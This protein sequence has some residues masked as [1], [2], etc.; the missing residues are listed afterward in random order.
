MI[1][2]KANLLSVSV[3][4]EAAPQYVIEGGEIVTGL[5]ASVR[6]HP[7]YLRVEIFETRNATAVQLKERHRERLGEQRERK[8]EFDAVPVLLVVLGR[9]YARDHK[10]RRK[11]ARLKGALS[12][13]HGAGKGSGKAVPRPV[14]APR[15]AQGEIIAQLSARAVIDRVADASLLI[16]DPL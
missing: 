4:S 12:A 7:V 13:H 9:T 10:A 8:L 15:Y 5:L 16:G 2:A 11:L 6:E 3:L 1:P 14:A